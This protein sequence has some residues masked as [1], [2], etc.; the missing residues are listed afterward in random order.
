MNNQTILVAVIALIIG[1]FGG[2]LVANNNSRIESRYGSEVLDSVTMGM[3]RMADGSLM[4][5]AT[6]D[7]GMGGMGQMDH[8]MGMMVKSEREF[9]D[10]MIPHH[11]EAVDT[12]K[13]VIAR[14]GSTQEVKKLVE[15]IVVAQE[16]EIADMKSWY[17]AWY[18]VAYTDK[19]TYQ[20]MMRD[21]SAL[22]GANLDKVFLEDMIVH[23]MGAIMMAQSV[24]SYIEHNE[25]KTLTQAIVSSQSAEIVQMRQMLRGL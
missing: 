17:Q 10:G 19:G 5:N 1:S 25:M 20:P 14:G 15:N 8:M 23:H 2:Y 22:S 3:Q 16:K 13:E 18:G 12:A 4:G 24:Q 11:Q 9:L 21:L 7:T 6:S